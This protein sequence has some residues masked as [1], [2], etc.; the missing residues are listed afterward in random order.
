MTSRG[1]SQGVMMNF[2]EKS[3]VCRKVDKKMT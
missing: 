2:V 1:K 3:K